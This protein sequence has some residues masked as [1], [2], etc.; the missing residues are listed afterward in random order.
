MKH[1]MAK[2]GLIIIIIAWVAML[3]ANLANFAYGIILPDMMH[4]LGFTTAEAGTLGSIGWLVKAG[5]TIPIALFVARFKPKWVLSLVYFS[6]F[7]GLLLFGAANSVFM[8][9]VGKMLIAIALGGCVAPLAMVKHNWFHT[10]QIANMNGIENFIAPM[11]QA[12]GTAVMTYF[13]AAVGGWRKANIILGVIAGIL[14]LLWILNYQENPDLPLQTG[15]KKAF[16]EPL[17]EAWSHRSVRLLMFGWPGTGFVWVA[18]YT[19]WPTFATENLGLSLQQAGVILGLL[20]IGSAI[21]SITGA[22]IPKLIKSDKN[23][24]WP[25]GFIL[26]FLYF[27][28]TKFTSVALLS[29][30]S[31]LVGYGAYAFVPVALTSLFKIPGFS[32]E[33]ISVGTSCII[34]INGFGASLGSIVA[35]YLA[36]FVGLEMALAICCIS[37]VLFGVLTLFLPETGGP[38]SIYKEQRN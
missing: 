20:P 16:L 33:G 38:K 23:A 31:F 17:K 3:F 21:G 18:M 13:I 36:G 24:I 29:V 5:F 6:L 28:L 19:F 37:P 14:T 32:P 12:M 4:E 11:G 22:Q 10:D 7:A 2:R 30:C 25:W 1:K 9:Y 34:A 27:G 15:P 8:L 26:P 35:G